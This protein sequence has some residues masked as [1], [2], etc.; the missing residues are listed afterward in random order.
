MAQETPPRNRLLSPRFV[1]FLATQFLG[2]ANDN[3]FK[4]TLTML[5]LARIPDEARQVKLI[6][7]ATMLFPIPF[8]VFSPVAGFASGSGAEHGEERYAQSASASLGCGRQQP[9]RERGKRQQQQDPGQGEIDHVG[10]RIQCRVASI[11]ASASMGST[12]RA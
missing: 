3:A 9:P 11:H 6:A 4:F 2:A 1:S 5:V 12:P 7:L 10:L 8:L